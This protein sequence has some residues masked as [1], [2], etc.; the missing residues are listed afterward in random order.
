MWEYNDGIGESNVLQN[1]FTA[2]LVT[3]IGRKK[4]RYQRNKMKRQYSELSLELQENLPEFQCNPDMLDAFP[5]MARLDNTRLQQALQRQK[6]RDL[7][8]FFAKILGERSF[9]EI[10][11]DLGLDYKAVTAAYY[12][13]INRLKKEL[14]GDDG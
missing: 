9:V 11:A 8:I 13:M 6:E 5:L 7:Y 1:Q 3:A 12:R 4:H 10:A 14:R 2:Y